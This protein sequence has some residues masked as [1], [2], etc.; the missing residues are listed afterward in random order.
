MELSD[1]ISR[2][3]RGDRKALASLQVFAEG[4]DA[5]SMFQLARLY[6]VPEGRGVPTDLSVAKRWYEKAA[7][8]G[9]LYSQ[10]ALANMYDCGDGEERD[11]AK[12]RKWYEVAARQN[13]GEAQMHYARML[14]SGRGGYCSIKEAAQWYARAVENGHELAA[15]NLGLLHLYGDLEDSSDEEAFRL[16]KLA[17]DKLDGLAHLLLGEMYSSGRGVERSGGSA[18]FHFCVAVFLLPQGENRAKVTKYKESILIQVPDKRSLFE[19]KA[20]AFISE[21]GGH[22]II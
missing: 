19:K 7:H 14:Q 12:A 3:Q 15:T 17:A 4:G 21:R 13:F 10:Y 5:E 9:H 20:L 16:F 2:A 11:L 8:L 22:A 1:L 6:D 18:L